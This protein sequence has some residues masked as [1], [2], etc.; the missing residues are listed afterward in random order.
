MMESLGGDVA[1]K[2]IYLINWNFNKL[3]EIQPGM[4]FTDYLK[5]KAASGVDVRVLIWVNEYIFGIFQSWNQ[6]PNFNFNIPAVLLDKLAEGQDW[7]REKTEYWYQLMITNLEALEEL[8]KEPAL[9]DKA[10]AN[11]LDY[12]VGS[13]ERK[14]Y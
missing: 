12:P 11:T 7:L 10:L 1:K 8:R 9:A 13:S 4:L 2:G 3:F 14:S 6:P 5:T